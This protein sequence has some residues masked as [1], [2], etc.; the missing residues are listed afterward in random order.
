MYI[1]EDNSEIDYTDQQLSYCFLL[2]HYVTSSLSQFATLLT[3]MDV[4]YHIVG[5][6]EV[7]KYTYFAPSFATVVVVSSELHLQTSSRNSS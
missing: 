1:S 3:N 6:G 7:T 5:D 4:R 2:F